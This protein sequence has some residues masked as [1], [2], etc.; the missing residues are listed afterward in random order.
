MQLVERLE[1]HG[2]F[3][4]TTMRFAE[5]DPARVE[6]T[7]GRATAHLERT[8]LRRGWMDGLMGEIKEA[9]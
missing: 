3:K 6:K 2:T 4:V 7:G 9:S 5:V 1:D 8:G